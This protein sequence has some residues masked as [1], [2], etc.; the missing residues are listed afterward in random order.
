[1]A[2]Q[3]NEVFAVLLASGTGSRMGTAI[4][5]QFAVLADKTVLEHAVAA[6]E[7]NAF[8]EHIILV[9]HP[10]FLRRAEQICAAAPFTKISRIVEGGDTRFASSRAGVSAIDNP[11]AYVLI[12][13]VARPCVSE[14]IISQCVAELAH[15]DAISVAVP[16]TDT[17][18]IA[19]AGCVVEQ[20]PNR[21]DLY[22][23]QTPQGFKVSLIQ[24]AH[25]LAAVHGAAPTDDCSLVVQY[26]HSDVHLVMGDYQN[27]K[28]THPVDLVTASALLAAK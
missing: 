14:S 12:H 6:F 3:S 20:I 5:K 25:E 7:N 1:M 8:I 11:E 24:R 23:V 28:I 13:D 19:T 4:P 10:D 27:I 17:I 21:E 16:A 26:T 9:V 2:I 22:M 18:F 15:Y